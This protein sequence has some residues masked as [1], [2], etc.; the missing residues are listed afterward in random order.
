MHGLRASDIQVIRSVLAQF[1]EIESAWLY[2]SRALGTA[3]AGSDVD[4][5]IKGAGVSHETVTNIRVALNEE[6]PLPYHFDITN[7]HRVQNDAL[8]QHIDEAGVLI[9]PDH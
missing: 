4:M 8:K 7:Y 6:S 2:G 1:P 3:K 9:Y 5:A